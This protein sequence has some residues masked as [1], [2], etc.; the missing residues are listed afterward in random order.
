MICY[1]SKLALFNCGSSL[2]PTLSLS[3]SFLRFCMSSLVTVSCQHL[4]SIANRDR[5][6]TSNIVIYVEQLLA[7]HLETRIRPKATHNSKKH[8]PVST[9]Q[10][11]IPSKSQSRKK[12]YHVTEPPPHPLLQLIQASVQHIATAVGR[13]AQIALV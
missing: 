6:R 9:A 8:H 2:Q 4:S 1:A 5:N 11:S 7:T 13:K 12:P 3:Q 10:I